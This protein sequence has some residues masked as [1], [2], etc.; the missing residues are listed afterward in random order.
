MHDS[1]ATS[2]RVVQVFLIAACSDGQP[3]PYHLYLPRPGNFA[4]RHGFA[5]S[6]IGKVIWDINSFQSLGLEAV[7][8]WPS[9]PWTP[10]LWMCLCALI[11]FAVFLQYVYSTVGHILAACKGGFMKGGTR[12]DK[13]NTLSISHSFIAM[14]FTSVDRSLRAKGEAVLDDEKDLRTAFRSEETSRTGGVQSFQ[15]LRRSTRSNKAIKA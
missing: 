4:A 7:M 6:F 9:I 1:N 11:W 8:F 5:G 12:I 3:L 2:V 10:L 14:S 15:P 13:G